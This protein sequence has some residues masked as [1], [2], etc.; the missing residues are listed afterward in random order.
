[1]IVAILFLIFGLVS[2]PASAQEPTTG[3]LQI[4]IRHADQ[5]EFN[6]E[7]KEILLT[8]SVHIV[9]GTMSIRADK[10][11]ITLSEDERGVKKGIATGHVEIID[12]TRTGRA[13]KAIYVADSSE[14]ILSG[15]PKLTE[16]PNEIKA[17]RIVY[18]IKTRSMKAAGRVRGI[19]IP[20]GSVKPGKDKTK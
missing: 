12:G 9:R 1:M 20:S 10:I 11:E 18:N 3:K 5:A 7:K 13:N 6:S 14:I 4:E 2:V 17:E 16:G 8:G 19:F 15:N